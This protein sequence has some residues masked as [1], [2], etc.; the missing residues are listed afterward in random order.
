MVRDS[1]ISNPMCNLY[2]VTKSQEAIRRLFRVTRDLAGNLPPLPDIFPIK[3]LP[4]CAVTR[5]TANSS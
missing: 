1:V 3:W 2:S 5:A 4:S